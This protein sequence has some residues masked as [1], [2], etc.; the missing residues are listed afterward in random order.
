MSLSSREDADPDI[1]TRP[2]SGI[3]ARKVYTTVG[4]L[5]TKHELEIGGLR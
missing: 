3:G 5:R 4:R 2:R 1:P